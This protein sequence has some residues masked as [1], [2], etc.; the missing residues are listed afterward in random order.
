[1]GF[2]NGRDEILRREREHRA[3]MAQYNYPLPPPGDDYYFVASELG[4]G[5]DGDM[6]NKPEYAR[7]N[8][9]TV[10]VKIEYGDAVAMLAT[11]AIQ[12]EDGVCEP[13]DEVAGQFAIVMEL[14]SWAMWHNANQDRQVALKWTLYAMDAM[15]A[16]ARM[17]GFDLVEA[18][19]M[20][21]RKQEERWA[22]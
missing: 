13:L 6:R 19:Q 21:R 9:R 11:A 10:D 12:L 17:K 16:L 20:S 7:N 4:E 14:V 2:V 1:M 8:H 15:D 18:H 3:L 22:K 5:A